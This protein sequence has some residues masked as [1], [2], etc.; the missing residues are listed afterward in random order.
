MITIRM[1]GMM[2]EDVRL[3][4]M[5]IEGRI[6]GEA[7]EGVMLVIVEEGRLKIRLEQLPSCCTASEWKRMIVTVER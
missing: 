1:L 7:K 2:R 6:I 3:G 5:G 4:R